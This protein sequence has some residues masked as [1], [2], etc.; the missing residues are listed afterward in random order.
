MFQGIKDVACTLLGLA[1]SRTEL[2]ALELAEEKDRLI[3]A[4]ALMLTAVLSFVLFLFSCALILIVLVWESPNRIWYL[5]GI[6]AFF[7]IVGLYGLIR[8]KVLAK[9]VPFADTIHM[10]KE[11]VSNIN[12]S[13][14]SQQLAEVQKAS[15]QG[16]KDE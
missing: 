6:A 12:P 5:V 7:A 3:K 2:F 13:K 10:F 4:I 9:K 14:A 11:D 8:G 1:S 16:G 15:T